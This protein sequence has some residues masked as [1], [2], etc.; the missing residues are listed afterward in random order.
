MVNRRDIEY[1]VTKTDFMVVTTHGSNTWGQSALGRTEA[2]RVPFGRHVQMHAIGLSQTAVV[3]MGYFSVAI[4]RSMNGSYW[5]SVEGNP[6]K[7]AYVA[8]SEIQED[9]Y[10]DWQQ[11][12]NTTQGAPAYDSPDSSIQAPRWLWTITHQQGHS[13]SA[14]VLI[15]DDGDNGENHAGLWL[16]PNDA[17]YVWCSTAPGG[18]GG[19]N[20]Y[21]GNYVGQG[22]YHYPT[23][24]FTYTEYY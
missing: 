14:N 16:Q 9:Q 13:N 3:P 24:I 18:G 19:S 12:M 4:A 7:S 23:A 22:D 17:I 21:G 5:R 1:E 10:Y 15:N 8:Q 2:F 6:D 20:Y 11:G